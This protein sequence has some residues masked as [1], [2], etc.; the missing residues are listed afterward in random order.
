M[1]KLGAIDFDD[2]IL[3][4]LRDD[5]LVVFAGAGVSVG[6]PSNLPSFR[7]LASDIAQTLRPS[8]AEP[9]D[10]FLG[11]LHHNKVA[12][13]QRAAEVLSPAA[14]AP[15]ALHRD[16]LRLF[17]TADRIRL[18]TTNFDTHF[19]TAAAQLFEASPPVYCAPALP[20]GHDFEGIVHVHG[21]LSR[22]RDLVLTDAD[23]GRAY[24]T[25]GWARRFLVDVFRSYAVLFVG[26]SH[27]D[28]VMTYLARAL[29][30]AGTGGRFALTEESGSGKW[31]LLGI[32]PVHFKR[33]ASGDAFG[34]LYEGVRLFADFAVR[35][36]LDWQLRLTELAGRAPPADDESISEVEHALREV[37]TTRFLLDAIR[38]PQWIR[39]LDSRKHLD[40]LFSAGDLGERDI[41]LAQ[42][43]AGHFA[44]AHAG[45]VLQTVANHRLQLNPFF[46][47]IFGREIGVER[48]KPLSNSDLTRWTTVLL[49]NMPDNSDHYVLMWI[50][51][52]CAAQGC[53]DLAL[54][55]FLAMAQPRL[56]I[57]P[58]AIW[59][60]DQAGGEGPRL[61]AECAPRVPH[62]PL[63]EVWTK[64]LKTFLPGLEQRLLTG[65]TRHVEDV[66][67]TLMTWNGGSRRWDPV[68]H[69]RSA[70]E[71]HEQDIH[72]RAMDVLIDAGRDALECLHASTALLDAWIERL[73]TSDAALLRRLAVHAMAM[74]PSKLADDRLRW[75][76]GR[77]GLDRPVEH[78][79]VYRA[80]ALNYPAASDAVR[81]SIVDTVLACNIDASELRSSVERTAWFHFSWLSWLLQAKPDCMLAKAALQPITSAHPEW[82]PSDY[83]DFTHWVGRAERVLPE[84]PLSVE[85]LLTHPPAGRLDEL[86]N[87]QGN[88]FTG[89]HRDGL[90]VTVSDACTQDS[91]WG[92]ALAGLL[93]ER[94][95]W[96]CD[97]WPVLI[98]G[99]QQSDMDADGWR[100]LLQM[101]SSPQLLTLWRSEIANLLH[102]LV[103]GDGKPFAL[104]LLDAANAIALRLWDAS[105]SKNE[106]RGGWLVEAISTPAGVIVEFWMLGQSLLVKGGSRGKRVMAAHY[107]QRFTTA[108]QDQTQR[109]GLARTLLASQTAFL[110]GLD[111]GWTREHLIPLFSDPDIRKFEQAWDGFLMWGRLNPALVEALLPAFLAAPARLPMTDLKDRR[112]SFARFYAALCISFVS[113]PLEQLLPALF[114]DGSAEDRARFAMHIG[115]FLR[116][117][118]P[119]AKQQL[120]EGW[121]QRYWQ[122][123]LQGVL[124]A[125]DDEEIR[126]MLEWLAY[127]NAQLPAAV[128]LAMHFPQVRIEHSHLLFQLRESPLVTQYPMDTAE[129]LI[130]LCGCVVGYLKGELGLV[131]GRLPALPVELNRRVD[132][133]L[134]LAGIQRRGG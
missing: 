113:D 33:S 101:V 92:L 134:A 47:R 128:A 85:Q 69:A 116:Q 111:E 129:L 27:D 14:S 71:P 25:L 122:G 49:A 26:Y 115:E 32:E 7:K 20:L 72:P 79:E 21:A 131:A 16:L 51:E 119:S 30:A 10:R 9:L 1:T 12:V 109:G 35:G 133:A 31:E 84:S 2:R 106:I 75:I 24:L 37:H 83:P 13:H 73:V 3:D 125:L 48:N 63:N 99:L 65:V 28:V 42:W 121:L 76:L 81:K 97:L 105:E 23:F 52:R 89:P 11:R 43:L 59:S 60:D 132:E 102:A 55:V 96:S 107:R 44:I 53:A 100:E 18:V 82:T 127:L 56:S 80:V 4:A 45:V 15:N 112:D 130:Y 39:W 8:D 98:R 124:G 86:L 61:H 117:M 95:L 78:H 77:L 38:D 66:H 17:R 41:L 110:F 34:A 64:S 19:E 88:Y 91:V 54:T 62:W 58:H 67:Q 108:L 93:C 68:S 118:Q 6:A 57:K 126:Q 104:E 40:A 103:K 123:R 87:F 22:P 46:W 29:P 70:I 36:A 5:K 90:L 114:H 94:E 74:H 120:W 50:A